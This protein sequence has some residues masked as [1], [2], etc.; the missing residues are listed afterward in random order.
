MKRFFKV[1]TWTVGAIVALFIAA[2]I[3]VLL[4]F[5]PNKYKAEIAAAVQ[6]ATGRE[7]AIQG[8]LKLSLFPWLGVETGAMSLSNAPGFGN[9][10]FAKIGGAAIKVK[11]LPL[12]KKDVEV[13]TVTVDGLYLHLVRSPSGQ[14][15]W[16]DLTTKEKQETTASPATTNSAAAPALSSFAIGG[17]RVKDTTL[18]WDDRQNKTRYELNKLALHTGPVSPKAPVTLELDTEIK[19]I[20]PARAAHLGLSTQ[21]LYD[22]DTQILQLKGLKLTAQTHGQELPADQTKLTLTTDAVLKFADKYYQLNG[23]RL[24][25]SLHGDKLPGKQV[26]AMLN[27]NVAVDL[28]KDTLAIEALTL[29]AWNL[30][31]TGQIQGHGLLEAP[32]FTGSLTI[33]SFNARELLGRLAGESIDTAD[34]HALNAVSAKLEFSASTKD[35]ELSKLE[36]KLDQTQVTGKAAIKNFAR[37]GYRFQL[38]LDNIDADRYLPPSTTA[39]AKPVTPAAVA[40]AGASGL[41]L[42]T[43]RALDLDGEL[44]VGKL[45]IAKLRVS[46]IKLG[47]NAK[48][49]VI[50]AQPLAA[51]L[52]SGTYRGDLQLDAR[53]KTLQLAMNE[54]LN[55]IEIG[56]LTK[57]L[58]EKDLVAGTGNVNL[59]L[60]GTG[61]TPDEL[62]RTLNGNL[63]FS[64]QNG[65]VNGVNLVEM[66]QKDYLEYI[67]GL[68]ADT[69]KLNQTVFSKFGATA[70]ATNGLI[71]TND[72]ALNSAQ[73]NVIGRGTANLVDERLA[74]RLDITPVGQLAKQL[75][76]F[77]DVVIPVEVQGTYS[78]PVFTTNLDD[79]LKQKLAAELKRKTE[80]EKAK[81]QQKLKQK[82]DQLNE[83]IQEQLQNKLKGLFK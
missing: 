17:V 35:A 19:S 27:S 73:L 77:K 8:D 18:I 79:V 81:L 80:E 45:K 69:S 82:Q 49:G 22:F 21:A 57:D 25:A 68:V 7:L 9:E 10:P 11:L 74:L 6:K 60:T 36:V 50:R 43:L 42:E 20:T 40:G 62:K 32:H 52:Y 76:Q 30:K 51:H 75:G 12:L 3:V 16:D 38:A 39:N 15:N 78:A 46:D 13:D 65:R 59:K 44:A 29:E 41:P 26:D 28:K 63:G 24:L 64:L 56:P 66:I 34:N 55:G 58:L 71:S 72:L 53:G 4:V 70:T 83:K 23:L 5:D 33:P 2:V 67:Q 14:T 31:V 61:I 54:A 1:T 48:S 47:I 37:P